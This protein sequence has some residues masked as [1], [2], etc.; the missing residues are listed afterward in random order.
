MNQGMDTLDLKEVSRELS[1]PVVSQ[2]TFVFRLFFKLKRG[3]RLDRSQDMVSAKA[4]SKSAVPDEVVEREE[5]D[6]CPVVVERLK[7][8]LNLVYCFEEPLLSTSAEVTHQLYCAAS[9]PAAGAVQVLSLAGAFA[10]D[11][12]KSLLYS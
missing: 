2:T 9:C 7:I 8:I 3:L 12:S 11:Q 1:S 10:G 6:I 4:V 5:N